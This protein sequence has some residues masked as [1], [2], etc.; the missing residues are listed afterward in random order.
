MQKNDSGPKKVAEI[1]KEINDKLA[2]ERQME[3]EERYYEDSR[4]SY[5]GDR[6]E[7]GRGKDRG[8]T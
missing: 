7:G 3:Q 2:K 4:G 1:H 8:Q 5:K 6:R